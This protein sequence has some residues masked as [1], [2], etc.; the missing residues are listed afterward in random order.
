M[1]IVPDSRLQDVVCLVLDEAHKGVKNHPYA[2]CTRLIKEA[3]PFFRVLALSA[4]PGN[5]KH[6][7]Q[8]LILSLLIAKIEVRDEGSPDVKEY[9]HERQVEQVDCPLNNFHIGLR[10]RLK[11]IIRPIMAKVQRKGLIYTAEPDMMSMPMLMEARRKLTLDQSMT[12]AQK[13][14]Y[15]A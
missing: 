11:Q 3:T 7:I 8:E 13:G 14:I 4:T 1:A 6:T 5:D 2:M 15:R 10:D 9:L 12:Q